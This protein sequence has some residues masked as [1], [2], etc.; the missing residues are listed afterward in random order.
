LLYYLY[1]R[2]SL[3][4]FVLLILGLVPRCLGQMDQGSIVGTVL[5]ATGAAIANAKVTLANEQ[6][7]FTLER[8]ADGSGSYAF[9][10]IKIGI[11]TVTA[12]TQGFPS[13]GASA[14]HPTGD[15]ANKILRIKRRFSLG[16]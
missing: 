7:G 15:V 12:S 14:P 13:L 5:D 11:Y 4:F 8:T 2:L 16:S 3:P 9:T 6:T 10:P 1:I